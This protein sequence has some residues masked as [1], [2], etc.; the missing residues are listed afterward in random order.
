MQYL[1][2][3][4]LCNLKLVLLLIFF[5]VGY[6]FIIFDYLLFDFIKIDFGA[7]YFLNFWLN[8]LNITFVKY[9]LFNYS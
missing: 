8:N 6:F 1:I 5:D 2:Y 3:L 9:N 7:F 4:N